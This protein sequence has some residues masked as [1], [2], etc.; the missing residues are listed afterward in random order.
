[1]RYAIIRLTFINYK[2]IV[3]FEKVIKKRV[4]I[5]FELV[6]SIDTNEMKLNIL[7]NYFANRKQGNIFFE[8]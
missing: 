2:I 7:L 5:G 4:I 3:Y 6:S 8:R 1:M